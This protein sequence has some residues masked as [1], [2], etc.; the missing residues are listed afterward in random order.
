MKGEVGRPAFYEL[1]EF[2]SLANVI[3]MAGGFTSQAFTKEIRLLRKD[4]FGNKLLR[5]LPFDLN[6]DFELIN[7]DTIE[8]GSDTQFVKTAI[9]LSGEVDRA[10]EYEW[11]VDTK[12]SDII[13][14]K[15]IFKDNAD[16]NYAIIRRLIVG[17]PVEI[18][19]FSPQ[20]LI[21]GNFDSLFF[22]R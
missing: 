21:E 2:N 22:R 15:W 8:V 3:E 5:I 16:L 10:G 7:G 1:D 17:G 9:E 20:K 18:I 13:T 14:N 4:K 11:N 19:S 6:K 12:L